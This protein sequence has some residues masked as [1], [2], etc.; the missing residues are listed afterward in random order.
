MSSLAAIEP[1]AAAHNR[2]RGLLANVG[3]DDEDQVVLD[4]LVQSTPEM[5]VGLALV[6]GCF[7]T[8]LALFL[9]NLT[10][11]DPLGGLQVLS[12]STW[13]AAGIGLAVGCP[14]AALRLFLWSAPARRTFPMLE[15][16]KEEEMRV[17]TPFLRDLNP[18]QVAAVAA[19][20]AVPTVLL[21][22]PAAQGGLTL[23]FRVYASMIHGQQWGLLGLMSGINSEALPA[24]L[25]I[26][27]T[28]ALCSVA[29]WAE[30]A[31][32][33]AEYEVVEDA[34]MGA[35][36]Y[37]RRLA[38]EPGRQ[39]QIS[40]DKMA[41]AFKSVAISWIHQHEAA[42]IFHAFHRAVDVVILGLL[43]YATG[44]LA[45]PLVATLLAEGSD[46]FAAYRHLPH[47][48]SSLRQ[49]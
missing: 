39:D 5:K 3:V 4:Q 47:N 28:A 24:V 31:T 34:I 19:A 10:H 9:C 13:T 11:S 18:I 40:P 43:W 33:G 8:A 20:D 44:N 22:L 2:L 38:L 14:L 48:T 15:A 27:L 16:V 21:L 25:A 30:L 23:S 32:T 1:K 42:A 7:V 29:H 41:A 6:S 37:Y 36:R 35:D 49:Q 12:P 46:V 45:A 26:T 17:L